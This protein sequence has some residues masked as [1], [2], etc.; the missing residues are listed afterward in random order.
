VGRPSW[1]LSLVNQPPPKSEF[2]EVINLTDS[3][4]KRLPDS[5]SQQKKTTG[6]GQFSA[7]LTSR[8][9]AIGRRCIHAERTA[10]PSPERRSSPIG[11]AL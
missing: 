3:Q 11:V 7:A 5:D 1:Q 8:S 10:C 9:A 6:W 4:V 2:A